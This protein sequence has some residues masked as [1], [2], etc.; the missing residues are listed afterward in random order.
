MDIKE[1]RKYIMVSLTTMYESPGY[2]IPRSSLY[3]ALGC[4]MP[5]FQLIEDALLTCGKDKKPFIKVTSD[6][7]T[8]LQLG[9]DTAIEIEKIF[10]EGKMP[11]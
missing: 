6:T 2:I 5:D 9:I 8:L 1:L 4:S 3:L 7:W 11:A 10:K